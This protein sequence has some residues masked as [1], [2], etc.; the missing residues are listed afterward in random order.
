MMGEG[1][2]GT[3]PI[4]IQEELKEQQC[5]E[6]ITLCFNCWTAYTSLVPVSCKR[7]VCA[8][9]HAADKAGVSSCVLKQFAT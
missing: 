6:V 7:L 8:P 3:W 4:P 2:G 9:A 1:A 5:R